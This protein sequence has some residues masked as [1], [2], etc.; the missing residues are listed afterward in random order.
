MIT[1]M[2]LAE[3]R[4]RDGEESQEAKKAGSCDLLGER[5]FSKL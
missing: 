5:P 2:I 4:G 3:G 1:D